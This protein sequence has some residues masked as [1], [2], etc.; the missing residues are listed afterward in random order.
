VADV[1]IAFFNDTWWYVKGEAH[2]DDVLAG[3]EA[4]ELTISLVTCSKWPDV[5]TLWDEPKPGQMPWAINPKIIER[6]KLRPHTTVG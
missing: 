1:V 5:M 4:A 2:I 3:D 6:L